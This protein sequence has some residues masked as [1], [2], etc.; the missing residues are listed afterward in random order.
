MHSIFEFSEYN[1]VRLGDIA[2]LHSFDLPD[3]KG[4]YIF[5]SKNQKFIYPNGQSRIIYIGKAKSLRS[6][7]K[8][9]FRHLNGLSQLNR[10]EKKDMTWYSRYQYMHKF[11]CI[12][13]YLSSNTNQDPKNL[14]SILLNSF[15]NRYLALL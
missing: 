9:H 12:I 3:T 8:T 6:R 4:V 1:P 15:Y 5:V 11:G 10:F 14:E 13:Y 2:E 7:L